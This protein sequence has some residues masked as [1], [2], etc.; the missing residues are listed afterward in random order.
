M[1]TGWERRHCKYGQGDGGDRID[2][3]RLKEET[4]QIP[5]GW[6]RRQHIS[7][8]GGGGDRKDLNRMG[9]RAE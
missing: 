4:E 8:Q 5:T 7:G 3:D 6:R 2:L 9:E 1:S